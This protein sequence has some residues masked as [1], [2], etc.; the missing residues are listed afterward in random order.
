MN[1]DE[2]RSNKKN[3]KYYSILHH[4]TVYFKNSDFYLGVQINGQNS[5]ST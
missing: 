5:L 4:I 3:P 1:T 2:Q